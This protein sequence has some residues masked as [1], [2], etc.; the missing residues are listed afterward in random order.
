MIAASVALVL[1]MGCQPVH[2]PDTPES[3]SV[4]TV[5]GEPMTSAE[6]T[7]CL[8][9]DATCEWKATPECEWITV[10]PD[11]GKRG[12][13]EVTLSYQA[14]GTGAD[15]SGTVRFTAGSYSETYTLEQSK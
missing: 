7:H 11:S 14:N 2:T 4:R 5:A 12:I 1:L 13:C 8:T 15:R 3:V 10:T 6:G 9:I